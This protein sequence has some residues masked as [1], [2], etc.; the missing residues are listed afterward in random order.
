MLTFEDEQ[1]RSRLQHQSG[2]TTV[3]PIHFYAFKDLEKNVRKQ[4]Q[5]IKSHAWVPGHIPVRGFIYDVKTGR[6]MEVS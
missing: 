4:I 2:T 3:A 1:L 5:K 6:L